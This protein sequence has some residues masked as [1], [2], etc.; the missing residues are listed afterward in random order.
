[1]K[2]IKVL[3]VP[4]YYKKSILDILKKNFS[5]LG[6]YRKVGLIST[7]QH[8]DQLD[9]LKEFI[10]S[11][12][13]KAVVG[14]QILGCSQENAL[15]IDG[16]IDAYVYIGSGLFHPIGLSVKTKK[17]VYILNPYSGSLSLLDDSG[18][19]RWLKRQ[20]GRLVRAMQ[21]DSYGI[22]I[23]TKSGQFNLKKAFDVRKKFSDRKVFL[24]A[25]EELNPNNVL[26]FKVD[27]WI[28]TACP[29]LVDDSFEK[30]VVN[31]DE[32]DLL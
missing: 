23:S 14:G 2:D 30:P 21:A 19:E 31:A 24:F 13:K 15:K 20:K 6:E 4:C 26:P 18:R 7:A 9:S 32:L 5:V 29:R 22:L 1:M 10:E 11:S 3:H 28:N 27:C 25:G 12:K 17:P 16:E 8:L